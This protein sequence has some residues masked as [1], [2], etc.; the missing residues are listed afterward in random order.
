MRRWMRRITIKQRNDEA[1]SIGMLE[2]KGHI[3]R[4]SLHRRC[5]LTKES[6]DQQKKLTAK[7]PVD[8]KNKWKF[9]ETRMV[10]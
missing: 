3:W 1:M 4:F 6:P 9:R 2:T 5:N 8:N 10:Y 7:S